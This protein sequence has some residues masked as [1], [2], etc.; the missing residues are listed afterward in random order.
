MNE[1]EKKEILQTLNIKIGANIND[2]QGALSLQAELAIQRDK[3]QST[4]SP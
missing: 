3:L 4:V 1:E 2:L